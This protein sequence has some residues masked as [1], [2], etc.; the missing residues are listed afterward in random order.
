MDY[1]SLTQPTW[2]HK[3]W[4]INTKKI[5]NKCAIFKKSK[6]S[7]DKWATRGGGGWRRVEG[8]M[9]MDRH[10]KSECWMK[11]YSININSDLIPVACSGWRSFRYDNI[12][13]LHF[14][15]HLHHHGEL[16]TLYSAC[17]ICDGHVHTAHTHTH[18]TSYTSSTSSNS[19]TSF[20]QSAGLLTNAALCSL[21][22]QLAAGTTCP[23]GGDL[24]L[25]INS[26]TVESTVAASPFHTAQRGQHKS[27]NRSWNKYNSRAD[28]M[29]KHRLWAQKSRTI[30]Y[31]QTNWLISHIKKWHIHM[32]IWFITHYNV[33]IIIVC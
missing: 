23:A 13:E 3:K 17:L 22:C 5:S 27:R 33:V 16:H 30:H 14:T 18:P 9:Q 11:T 25:W 10:D 20:I 28:Q 21:S 31:F 19:S 6:S 1:K 8:D 12:P 4:H 26:K 2:C 32:N 7:C 24:W 15:S 29:E